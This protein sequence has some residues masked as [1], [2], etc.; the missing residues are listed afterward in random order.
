MCPN[1]FI[2]IVIFSIAF[3]IYTHTAI[4]IA[5]LLF[6]NYQCIFLHAIML[7]S[8]APCFMLQPYYILPCCHVILRCNIH[9]HIRMPH[10]YCNGLIA[11]PHCHIIFFH[12][13]TIGI[14]SIATF[15]FCIAIWNILIC[16]IVYYHVSNWYLLIPAIPHSQCHIATYHF[17]VLFC[18]IK[19][20]SLPYLLSYHSELSYCCFAIPITTYYR[21]DAVTP[22]FTSRFAMLYC[23]AILHI[24]MLKCFHT[25]LQQPYGIHACHM[26]MYGFI[27]YP[28][29]NILFFHHDTFPY[30][31]DIVCCSFTTSHAT[32]H[33]L[34]CFATLQSW[35]IVNVSYNS[36]GCHIYSAFYDWLK[37]ITIVIIVQ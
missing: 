36:T 15:Y 11:Y 26:H 14:M 35:Y 5:I 24:A 18:H 20:L 25:V 6:C 29:C 31:S 17:A 9:M 2:R 30:D 23:A 13:I 28:D 33:L 7:F 10:T 16:H 19:V 3:I 1:L 32:C 4:S 12:Y 27:V 8:V 21:C 34:F 22:A 37:P